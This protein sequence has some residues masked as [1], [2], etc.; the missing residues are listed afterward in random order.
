M[1]RGSV[2]AAK[3]LTPWLGTVH[4]NAMMADGPILD[5]RVKV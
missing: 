1:V 4:K 5:H 2:M 3:Q